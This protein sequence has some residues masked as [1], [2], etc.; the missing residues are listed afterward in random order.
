[1]SHW[2]FLF[3]VHALKSKQRLAIHKALPFLGDLFLAQGERNTA[4]SLFAVALDGFVQ[5]DVHRNKGECMLRLADLAAQ[6]GE[7]SNSIE[8]WKTARSSFDGERSSQTAQITVV[9][10]RLASI[11]QNT[12]EGQ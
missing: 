11:R 3:L 5:M 10:E 7:L 4:P 2:T 6:D 1:M 9:D 12:T 8:L